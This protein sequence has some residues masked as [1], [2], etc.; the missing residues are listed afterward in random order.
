VK[1]VCLKFE[2][3]K[4]KILQITYSRLLNEEEILFLNG[5]IEHIAYLSDETPSESISDEHY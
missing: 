3:L 2:I 4:D 1:I 5:T